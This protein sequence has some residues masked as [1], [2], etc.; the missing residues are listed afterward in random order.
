MEANEFIQNIKINNEDKIMEVSLSVEDIEAL[1]LL[2]KHG[3]VPNRC[4]IS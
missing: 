4:L 2:E 3:E 1:K